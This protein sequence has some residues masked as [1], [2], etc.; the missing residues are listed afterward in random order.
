MNTT[1][2]GT[3]MAN[4]AFQA[5]EQIHIELMGG[6]EIDG[7]F[8]EMTK[9]SITVKNGI[10]LPSGKRYRHNATFYFSG[11][12]D[13]YAVNDRKRT[14]SQLANK[15]RLSASEIANCSSTSSNTKSSVE[16]VKKSF[17]RS[18]IQRIENSM[19][20]AV[21]ISQFDDKYHGAINELKQQKII[22]V[23]SEYNYGRL[24]PMRPVIA[25]ASASHRVYLFDM[26]R[27]GAMKTEFK[28]IF[29]A[30][31]PR[32][33]I[34]RCARFSDY[35]IHTEKCKLSNAFDTL[36]WPMHLPLTNIIS[37]STQTFSVHICVRFSRR[38]S[39]SH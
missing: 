33:V 18:E 28:G 38:W 2:F 14:E 30:N 36:V 31:S 11:I 34:H 39:I 35:L 5:N 19:A 21:Y 20:N 29:S 26:V 8:V 24:N 23:D 27:L 13:C 1:I 15:G 10:D 12:K 25:I 17:G 9:S 7:T 6:R 3:N 32:K 37:L 4:G 16:I 22:A